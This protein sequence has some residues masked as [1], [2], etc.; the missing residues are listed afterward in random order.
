MKKTVSLLLV[1]ALMLC[2]LISV[3]ETGNHPDGQEE[4]GRFAYVHDPRENPEAMKDI[5]DKYGYH[6]DK[7][8]DVTYPCY[9][10]S[11]F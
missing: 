11:T 9:F 3:A 2:S 6:S 5:I 8:L 10:R 1:L 4:T 7:E